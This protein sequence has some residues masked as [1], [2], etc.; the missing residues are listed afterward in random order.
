MNKK[1]LVLF[2][3]FSIA[4]LSSCGDKKAT[5]KASNSAKPEVQKNAMPKPDDEVAVIEMEQPAYGTIKI[6][7]YSNIAPKAVA[8][9][10][11]LAK[12]GYYNGIAFHRINESVIQAGDANTKNG[13]RQ[14][15][16][17]EGDSGKPN[18]DAEFSDIPFDTAILGAA[19]LGNDVNSANSQFFIMLKREAGFDSNYT[20]YG[21]VVEGMNYV[22]TIAGA[23][24]KE[25]SEEPQDDI[26]I[27]Q[28]RFEPR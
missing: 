2:F 13:T 19:R 17:K 23:P 8:R 20:V 25:N 1:F 10:K 5:N 6:E 11:E 22:R 24:K 3:I 15:G 12:E 14:P 28:I 7:L 27:K 9:F 16:M 18:V 26:K 21:K 4:I